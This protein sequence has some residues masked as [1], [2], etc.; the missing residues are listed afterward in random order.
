MC[1]ISV[2]NYPNFNYISYSHF[3][4]S[5]IFIRL[6]LPV[7]PG[8]IITTEACSNYRQNKNILDSIIHSCEKYIY[9][10]EKKCNKSLNNFHS[11]KSPLLLAV[12]CSPVM[13]L[14]GYDSNKMEVTTI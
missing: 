8:F 11:N 6:G 13:T 10:M 3:L 12:R 2:S 1:H 7:P 4:Y 9:D 5:H 14:T